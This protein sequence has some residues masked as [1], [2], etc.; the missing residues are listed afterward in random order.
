MAGFTEADMYPINICMGRGCQAAIFGEEL[1]LQ[2]A[3]ARLLER[4]HVVPGGS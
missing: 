1:W 3:N 4:G 2:E